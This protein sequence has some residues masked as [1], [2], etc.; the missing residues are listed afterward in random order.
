MSVVPA[1]AVPRALLAVTTRL[2]ALTVTGAVKGFALVSRS[3]EVALFWLTLVM[4]TPSEPETVTLPLPRPELVKA[5]VGLMAPERAMLPELAALVV[6]VPAPVVAAAMVKRAAPLLARV[7]PD[8]FMASV[9]ESVKT[10]VSLDWV[11]VFVMELM[12][13]LTERGVVVEPEYEREPGMATLAGK[14]MAPVP[15]RT[16]LTPPRKPWVPA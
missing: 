14:L 8:A 7:V 12:E 9:P 15:L 1:A 5:P 3:G 6:S 11:I 2:P 13:V 10:L 16:R 4:A